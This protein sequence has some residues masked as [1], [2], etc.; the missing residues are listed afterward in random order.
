MRV[1]VLALFLTALVGAPEAGAVY[2]YDATTGARLHKFESP[3]A[4]DWF[5]FS[6]AGLGNWA[7]VGAPPDSR[8]PNA[9]G[10]APAQTIPTSSGRPPVVTRPQRLHQGVPLP[11]SP[12]SDILLK[13]E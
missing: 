5:G 11:R 2:A 4:N 9:F 13:N 7:I 12:G 10:A 3:R 6:L 1:H 8:G